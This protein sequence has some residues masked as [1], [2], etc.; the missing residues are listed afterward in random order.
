LKL[1]TRIAVTF[2][3]LLAAVLGAALG[4]VSFENHRFAELDVRRQLDLGAQIYSRALESNRRLLAQAAL[5]AGADYGFREALALRDTDTL[6]SALENN[7][8]RIRAPLAVVASL[9]GTV[10]AAYGSAAAAGSAFPVAELLKSAPAGETNST[11]MVESGRIYQVVAARVRSPL[12]VAWIV[13]GFELDADGAKDLARITGLAVTLS[14]R[15]KAGWRNIVTATPVG[16]ARTADLVSQRIELSARPG[17]EVAAT[18]SGALGD[19]RAPFKTLTVILYLIAAISLLAAAAAIFGLARGITRPLR[20][21]THAVGQIRDGRYDVAVTVQRR[22]ELGLLADGLEVMQRAVR[23]RDESI[24]RLAYRDTLTGLMNRTAFVESLT[25]AVTDLR[26]RLAVAV[27]NLHRFRR[28]NEHLGYAVGD[29]VLKEI[30]RRLTGG[31]ALPP[32]VARLAADQFAAFAP[33]ADGMRPETW[34]AALLRRLAEPVVVEGQPIDISAMVGLASAPADAE[35]ADE[36]LRCADLA[37][38][39]ARRE[40]RPLALFEP[41]L[42]PASRDQLSLL[43]ELRRAIDQDELCLYFQPKMELATHR[44]VGAEV[45]L[46]W[47]HPARGLLGPGSFLPFAEQ[48]GFIRLITRWTLEKAVAQGAEW[49]RRGTPLPLAVNVSADDIVEL[50][51]DLRVARALAR[52][53]LPPSLLT[54]EVT[55]SG[56]IVDPGQAFAMLDG[57]SALGVRL[58]IDDFGTGYSSLSHLARMPVHEV[59]IDR[60]FVEGLEADGEFETV[61]RAAIDMGHGLGLKVVAEGIET[62]TAAQRL[63]EMGCDVAQGFLYAKAMPLAEFEAWVQGRP[64]IPVIASPADFG[65]LDLTDTVVLAI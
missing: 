20:D 42:Q 51:F 23:S 45:L 59:K 40:K 58:S 46:R 12:P 43:G 15:S 22:D 29:E 35:A 10:L 52:H 7:A 47:H 30:A 37:V 41:A 32:E 54:L 11:V 2:L 56:F 62:E 9:D 36:L 63:R 16:E 24:S 64:R 1:R 19:A 60:S 38:D 48:T 50:H 33:L 5:A 53:A 14:V 34:G 26:E 65:V 17:M 28:I 39:R 8:N 13:M 4:V 21:L 49:Y 31:A 25:R 18:L 3:L 44:V 57:L 27:I 6:A 55:E 61:V